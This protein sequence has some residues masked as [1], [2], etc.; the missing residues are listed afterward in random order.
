MFWFSLGV[1]EF[2]LRNIPQVKTHGDSFPLLIDAMGS[3]NIATSYVFWVMFA[4]F[5]GLVERGIRKTPQIENNGDS[6]P[7]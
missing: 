3:R 2:D 6:F 7:L 1:V 4:V 5:S